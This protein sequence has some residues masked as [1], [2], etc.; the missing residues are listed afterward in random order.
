[1]N[2]RLIT[3]PYIKLSPEI[4][5]QLRRLNCGHGGRMI[6]ILDSLDGPCQPYHDGTVVAIIDKESDKVLS[7][8]IHSYDKRPYRDSVPCIDIYTRWA[9]RNKGLGTI[10]AKKLTKKFTHNLNFDGGRTSI[11]GN[12][13]VPYQS[14]WSSLK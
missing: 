11:Y 4:K 6:E 9:Y 7:W 3:K 10:V 8:G 13:S 2:I 1:M 5:K 12:L 14:L